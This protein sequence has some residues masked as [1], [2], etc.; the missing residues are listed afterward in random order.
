MKGIQAGYQCV[1][2][3]SEEDCGAACLASICKY[4]GRMLSIN[5]S[6]DAVGTGQHYWV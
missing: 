5:R 6:R 2:Q 4:Y 3:A 1:L